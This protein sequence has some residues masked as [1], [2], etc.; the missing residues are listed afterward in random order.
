MFFE[1]MEFECLAVWKDG[2][3]MFLYGGFYGASIVSQEYSY[4]CFVCIN[5]HD[6]IY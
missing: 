2:S 4:R 3:D 5:F 1:D 6:L